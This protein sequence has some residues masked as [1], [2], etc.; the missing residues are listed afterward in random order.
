M[1]L[2]HWGVNDAAGLLNRITLS[3]AG[4]SDRQ[5]RGNAGREALKKG[6]AYGWSV[7]VACLPAEG[8]L[9]FERQCASTDPDVRWVI[10]E[11][12]K[13]ARLERMDAAWVEVCKERLE[14][15][16]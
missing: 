5:R 7:A 6:L 2:Q 11:N 9:H 12:L 10:R 16:T 14:R 4:A 3:F 13:K 8:R 1:A 15:K